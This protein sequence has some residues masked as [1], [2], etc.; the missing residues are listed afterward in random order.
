MTT[1]Y[2][3]TET[4]NETP[5]GAGLGRY[6]ETVQVMVFAW[7]L[8]D[9]PA[10]VADHPA[11]AFTQ[12]FRA[13]DS[14]I[15][16][17]AAFDRAVLR[18][19][20]YDAPRAKWRC[21]MAQAL[22]HSLPGSLGMLSAIYNLGDAAK[23]TRGRQL[24]QLF[25]KPRPKNSTIRRA[26][27]QTHPA[28][29]AQFLEYARQDVVA[30]RALHRKLPTWNWRAQDIADWHLQDAI[31][32]RGFQ[33]DLELARA[34]LDLE[35]REKAAL[36]QRTQDITG[37]DLSVSQRDALLEHLL[38]EYAVALPDLQ[39]STLERRIED[40][41]LPDPVRELLQIRLWSSK[42]SNA[43]W[44]RLMN[45]ASRDGRLRHTAQY[46]GASRTGRISG[47]VFQPLNLPR[48]PAHL[49]K[50]QREAAQWVRSGLCDLVYEA[51]LDV[52]SA[53]LRGGIIAAPGKK[54]LVADLN[55][56]EGRIT[57][58][59]AGEQWALD[60]YAAYDCGVGHEM[61]VRQYAEAFHVPPEA[62]IANDKAGG[63]WRQVGKVLTLLCGFGGSVGAVSKGV[64]L[65]G[66]EMSQADMKAAVNAWRR[67]NPATVAYWYTLEDACKTVATMHAGEQSVGR[68]NIVKQG[69]WLRIVL[70]SGRSLSYA[71]PKLEAGA[72]GPQLTFLGV[73]SYTRKWERQSTYGGKLT[74]N[75]VQAT[76]RDVLCDAMH[77]VEAAGM[78]IVMT[79]Y[80]E[81]VCEVPDTQQHSVEAL[82]AIM[83]TPPAWAQGLPLAASGYESDRY[84]KD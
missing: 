28:E 77:R 7:A 55:A 24:M 59:H 45:G 40:E 1:L 50:H 17:N 48:P 58:W 36:Q 14:I 81:I 22:A 10:Q 23:S 65:Y 33:V 3:D 80:D 53:C 56:I 82:C 69:A 6:M 16:H 57:A 67:A 30:L 47:R 83:S 35:Q 8:D 46:C 12:A 38:D 26:T 44:K 60:A 39:A 73:N 42:T 76:A 66:L 75:C 18:K 49:K 15:A 63:S 51:P 27:A 61:Y 84:R 72:Y 20:G 5:I 79:C 68:L 4:Y 62:V 52:A 32:D 31:N 78:P 71:N 21:T 9:G 37:T 25:C 70:P 2:L 54:L 34:A 41:N 11:H 43:K 13:A 29:W 74:E 19:E 64:A